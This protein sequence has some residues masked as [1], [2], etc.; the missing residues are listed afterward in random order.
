MQNLPSAEVYEK[1]FKYMS[2]GILI[3]EVED[4]IVKNAPKEG[5]VLD[6]LCGPGYLLGT[7]KG[8]RNDLECL[9]VDLDPEFIS[10]AKAKYPDINFEVADAFNWKSDDQYDVILVTAGLHHLPPEQQ[11]NFVQKVFTLL[12]PNGFAIVGDPYIDDYSN[13]KERKIAGAKLGYEYLAETIRNNGTEDMIDAAIQVMINDVK[14]V[15]WKSSVVKN[16]PVFKKYFSQV[17]MHKTWP[18]EETGYGDYYFILR[19]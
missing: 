2:W 8:K 6:L 13:E 4:Y 14:L 10:H 12:K 3:H 11:E 19:K 5:K 1:E 9:G 18:K 15:E 16:T 7:L 17:E